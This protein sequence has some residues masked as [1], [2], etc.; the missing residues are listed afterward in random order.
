MVELP[1]NKMGIP[2]VGSPEPHKHLRQPPHRTYGVGDLAERTIG[3]AGG[4]G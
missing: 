4:A 3:G 2:I 1:D